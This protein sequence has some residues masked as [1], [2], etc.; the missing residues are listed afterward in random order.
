MKKIITN[1]KILG[2]FIKNYIIVKNE[3]ISYWVVHELLFTIKNNKVSNG[4]YS[5]WG[6]FEN[7]KW[8]LKLEYFNFIIDCK[9]WCDIFPNN[10][11]EFIKSIK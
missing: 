11:D 6:N 3:K 10:W 4:H 9:F 1:I 5:S 2:I 7:T 8:I